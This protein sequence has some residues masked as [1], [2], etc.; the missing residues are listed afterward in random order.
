MVEE[1]G[2]VEKGKEGTNTS[3]QKQIDRQIDRLA[4][5]QQNISISSTEEEKKGTYINSIT[6]IL[7]TLSQ[8]VIIIIFS[9]ENIEFFSSCRQNE[10]FRIEIGPGEIWS[11]PRLSH[12]IIAGIFY[13]CR[14]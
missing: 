3:Y 1:V 5:R 6:I 7:T 11:P 14:N 8:F 13:F 4:G 9:K 12:E 2:E 10:A